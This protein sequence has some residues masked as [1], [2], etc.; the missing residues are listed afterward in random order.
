[1][2]QTR[3]PSVRR[4]RP[5]SLRLVALLLPVVLGLGCAGSDDKENNPVPTATAP[6][7]ST[8]TP[9][10]GANT[11]TPTGSQVPATATPTR[12][13]NVP[14]A[15]ATMAVGDIAL[16]ACQKLAA[17]DQCFTTERGTCLEPAQCATRLSEDEARCINAVT[18]CPQS[19]LGD[20]L[21][22][23]CGGDGSGDCE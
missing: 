11:A 1:M 20:C 18:G 2:I 13:P 21:T 17:C 5:P 7:V 16:A 15:T 23:G 19:N 3:P 10:S 4:R 12:P 14:T 6:S 22:V 9:T 8:A